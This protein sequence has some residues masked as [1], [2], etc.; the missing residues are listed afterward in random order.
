MKCLN[1][2]DG[3]CWILLDL[4]LT[5]VTLLW[6]GFPHTPHTFPQV[7]FSL[8]AWLF[9][10]GLS[11]STYLCHWV[12]GVKMTWSSMVLLSRYARG[13][14]FWLV[15][16]NPVW[17]N[18]GWKGYD[19]MMCVLPVSVTLTPV[20]PWTVQDILSNWTSTIQWFLVPWTLNIRPYIVIS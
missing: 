12:P 20:A 4:A 10:G 2:Q 1:R 5:W 16:N 17:D 11:V 18:Y 7:T 9:C 14:K 19:K 6:L 3:P 15:F 13:L 8:C